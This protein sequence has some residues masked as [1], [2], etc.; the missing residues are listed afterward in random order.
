MTASQA[1]AI[2]GG[3]SFPADV[4]GEQAVYAITVDGRFYYRTETV[5][6]QPT[7]TIEGVAPGDYLVFAQ[8]RVTRDP[9]PGMPQAQ[10]DASYTKAIACGL[11][12]A[13]TDH[14]S[15]PIHVAAGTTTFGVDPVDWYGSFGLVPGNP[16]H[17]SIPKP[18]GFASAAAA[19]RYIGQSQLQ[20]TPVDAF[21]SCSPNAACYV[22]DSGVTTGQHAAY[23]TG[24]AGSNADIVKCLLYVIEDGAGWQPMDLRC[25]VDRPQVPRL[26]AA[27]HVYRG[28][29]DSDKDCVNVRTAPSNDATIATCLPDGSAVTVDGG[30][31]FAPPNPPDDYWPFE[32]WW[33]AAGIGWVRHLNVYA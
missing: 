7:Y 30:P 18:A 11:S 31:T 28:K 12:V 13:C 15:I 33:H 3:V 20:A 5:R 4:L 27:A 32:V 16:Q 29:I 19:A 2:H 26:G 9:Y 23:L 6:F 25:A 22:L 24:T 10:F 8:S 14:T 1:G 21:S 17:P